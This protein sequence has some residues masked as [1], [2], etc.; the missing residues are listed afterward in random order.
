MLE[1]QRA[2][3]EKVEH[4]ED[5][6]KLLRFLRARN[7][8]LPRAMDMYLKHLKWREDWDVD[9]ILFKNF[10]ERQKLLDYYP[11]GYH[12]CDKQGRPIYIQY[13]GGINVHKILG[14]TN[15]ETILKIFIQEYEKFL[16]FKVS[17]PLPPH[18]LSISLRLFFNLFHVAWVPR[19]D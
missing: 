11:Q 1:E 2:L 17:F 7:F 16:H 8:D 6:K 5:E 15:Q 3:R 12:M 19:H 13:L 18:T 4:L 9:S 10:P 14:F